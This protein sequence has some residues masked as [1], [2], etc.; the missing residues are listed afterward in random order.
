[1]SC[2]TC[3]KILKALEAFKLNAA[4]SSNIELANLAERIHNS[5]REI[6]KQE[7]RKPEI[8]IDKLSDL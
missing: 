6:I 4:S 7:S 1:M 2:N 3:E 8:G 5:V